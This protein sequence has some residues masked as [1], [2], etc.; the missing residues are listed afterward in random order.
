MYH[1]SSKTSVLRHFMA[2]YDRWLSIVL[3]EPF[4]DPIHFIL[5]INSTGITAYT[6]HIHVFT[7]HL[8]NRCY[9]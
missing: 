9:T 7:L 8:L 3:Y 4:I 2:H 1:T 5:P 6:V